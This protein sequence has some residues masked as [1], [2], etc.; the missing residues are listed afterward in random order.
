MG[1]KELE[2]QEED[3]NDEEEKENTLCLSYVC[4]I[5]FLSSYANTH[6]YVY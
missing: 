4:I 2:V 1:K 6:T 5:V 3:E